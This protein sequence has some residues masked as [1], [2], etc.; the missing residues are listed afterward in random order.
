MRRLFRIPTGIRDMAAWVS[1]R[2]WLIH[3]SSMGLLT[4]AVLILL[5][6]PIIR[7][8]FRIEID[9]NEGWNVYQALSAIDGPPLYDQSNEWASL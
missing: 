2:H 3:W 5:V 7:M 6:V 1:T 9:Y 8:G 4:I